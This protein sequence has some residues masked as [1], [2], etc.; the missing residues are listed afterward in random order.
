MCALYIYQETFIDDI[1]IAFQ[2]EH[3]NMVVDS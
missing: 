1:Y 3:S 2:L